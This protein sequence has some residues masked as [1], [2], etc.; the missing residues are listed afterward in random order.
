M[1][2]ANFKKNQV[3]LNRT[4]TPSYLLSFYFLASINSFFFDMENEH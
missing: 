2:G 4:K 3:K 1:F